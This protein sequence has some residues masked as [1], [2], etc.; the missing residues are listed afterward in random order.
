MELI[1][2]K[3][4]RYAGVRVY[5][6][7]RGQGRTVYYGHV[8]NK[9]TAKTIDNN[10]YVDND[11]HPLFEMG[12]GFFNDFVKCVIDYA[13]AEGVKSDNDNFL[14]GKLEAT[15]KHLDDTRIILSKVID[16]I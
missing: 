6:I 12:M 7:E 4:H 1:V 10:N 2:E 15:E 16:K 11:I 8:D 13:N 5:C 9:I 14:L 3:D